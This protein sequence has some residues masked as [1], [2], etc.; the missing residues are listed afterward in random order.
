MSGQPDNKWA[1]S[2][3]PPRRPSVAGLIKHDRAPQRE[4]SAPGAQTPPAGAAAGR[5]PAAAADRPAPAG[6]RERLSGYIDRLLWNRARNAFLATSYDEA[7][8]SW[9]DF[10]AKAIMAEAE[11]R[12]AL[13][14]QGRPYPDRPARVPQGRPVRRP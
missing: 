1:V 14:N 6:A 7:D 9:S 8:Q 13:Y 3:L 5:Q 12:E 11:R 4:S 10:M 2:A